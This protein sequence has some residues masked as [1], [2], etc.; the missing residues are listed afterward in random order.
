M[1]DRVLS[2]IHFVSEEKI[3][4]HW[5]YTYNFTSLLR[6]REKKTL[7]KPIQFAILYQ[8]HPHMTGVE[9]GGGEVHLQC[10]T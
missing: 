3:N 4:K 8:S 9:G 10:I 2:P 7:K 1:S 5:P 6:K